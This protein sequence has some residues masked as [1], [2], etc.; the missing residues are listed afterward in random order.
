MNRQFEPSNSSQDASN[1]PEQQSPTGNSSTTN[2][3]APPNM[4]YGRAR[5]EQAPALSVGQRPAGKGLL[6]NFK[7]SQLLQSTDRVNPHSISLVEQDTLKQPKIQQ[8][9]KESTT[10][11]AHIQNYPWAQVSPHQ[12]GISLLANMPADVQNVP[13]YGPTSTPRTTPAPPNL[14]PFQPFVASPHSPDQQAFQ[15][16]GPL[17]SLSMPNQLQAEWQGQPMPIGYQGPGLAGAPPFVQGPP[18]ESAKNGR[19]KKKWRFPIW[20]RVVVA[21]LTVF[22][23]LGGSL[24]YYYQ[25]N[26]AAPVNGI[27]G[28]PVPR[29]KSDEAPNQ[30]RGDTSGGILG[31]GRINILLLGSDDDY[32]SVHIYGGI[33]AQTDIVVSINP[34]TQS[35]SMLSIPRDSWVNVPGYGMH[36]LDQAYLLGGGGANGAAL[37][38]ATIH[39]DFGIYIDHYAWVGL[40]GFTKVIQTVGGVDVDVIHP[41]TDDSYPDDTGKGALDPFALKRLYIAPGPQH[42]MDLA[43]LEYVRSRH[44]DLV[45]DFGRSIRQQQVLNQLKYKLDNPNVI[46]QLPVLAQDLNGSV[47]TDMS[48]QDVFKLMY[49]AKSVDQSK[50]NKVTLGPPYSGDKTINTNAGSQDVVIL[51]CAR[52]QPLIAK[53]F[54]IGN[55]AR[56][57]QANSGNGFSTASTLQTS[58]APQA[59]V[60]STFNSPFQAVHQIAEIS[61]M[62]LDWNNYDFL[63]IHSLLDLLFLVVFESPTA[64][65]V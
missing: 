16:V 54:S 8:P 53:M 48:L 40:S 56:C 13:A 50:I 44:A 28:Q 17:P 32:K 59:V 60:T 9:T 52:V 26:F 15:A 38:M 24:F 42:L 14:Q 23:V 34:A 31:G 25:V 46:G 6:S 39:Q 19:R 33:L 35:V 3:G 41:I 47:K 64:L 22:I 57:D 65:Q 62:S 10:D 7:N 20:A 49:Y 45:G 27:V 4:L 43:A 36:K 21:I 55:N 11:P 61:T 37:S 30:G 5:E 63:G 12:S 18:G 1:Q 51:D 2:A 58:P 29:L